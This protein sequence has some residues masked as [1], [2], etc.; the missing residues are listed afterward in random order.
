MHLNIIYTVLIVKFE[1]NMYTVREDVGNF[2]Y[3]VNSTQTASF[4]YEVIVNAMDGTATCES[5][6][7]VLVR[8]GIILC[9]SFVLHVRTCSTVK[10]RLPHIL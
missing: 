2:S 10:N 4:P 5:V 9:V 1:K 8:F 7:I 3:H 6:Y